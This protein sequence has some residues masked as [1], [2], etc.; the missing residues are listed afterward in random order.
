[1]EGR[2]PVV[3]RVCETGQTLVNKNHSDKKE[4][5]LRIRN[6]KDKWAE[7]RDLAKARRTRLEDAIEAQQVRETCSGY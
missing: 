6:L 1:M 3:E 5:G 7:L 4:I 2:W